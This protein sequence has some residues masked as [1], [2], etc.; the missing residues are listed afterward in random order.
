MTRR[1]ILNKTTKWAFNESRFKESS[2]YYLHELWS[3]TEY[4]FKNLEYSN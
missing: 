2:T 1:Y 3:E 4:K